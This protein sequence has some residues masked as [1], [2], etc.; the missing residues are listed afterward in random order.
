MKCRP[1][2][3]TLVGAGLITLE[4]CGDFRP[5]RP[6]PMETLP[7]SVPLGTAERSKL[8]L[9]LAAG[10]LNLTG[11]ASGL[12]EGSLD[13][14]VPSWKPEVRTSVV[15]SSTDIVIKHPERHGIPGGGHIRWD[16]RVSDKV[17]L[18][19]AIHAGAGKQRI[20]LGDAKLRS[21]EVNIGAG[22]VD[23]DLRGRPTRDYDISVSGGVGQASVKLPHDVGIWAE[24]H[25]GIGN[26]SVSG[27]QKKDGHWENDLYDNAKVN[28]H[29]R[30]QGGIG[31]INISAL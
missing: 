29:V 7:V 22:Q 25:G 30:V 15:G 19:V 1:A 2:L 31:E 6:G 26:I 10:E 16:L 12:L 28:V 20:E 23:L 4:G 14:N 3:L 13:Y 17:L 9:N 5:E 27:L 21:V 11:G 8:E 24:A 18:D